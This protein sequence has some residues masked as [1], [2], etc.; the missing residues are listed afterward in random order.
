ML[1]PAIDNEPRLLLPESGAAT[2]TE[3]LAVP[4]L[5][6][7]L[8]SDTTILLKEIFIPVPV[9]TLFTLNTAFIT[10]ELFPRG[11]DSASSYTTTLLPFCSS[12][13]PPVPALM[14]TSETEPS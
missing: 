6:S 2:A 8:P 14:L 13:Q 11:L 10:V 9:A 3:Y 12:F 4:I 7:L 5:L 1:W